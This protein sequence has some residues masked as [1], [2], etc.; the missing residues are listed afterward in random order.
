METSPSK[1]KKRRKL[2]IVK[3]IFAGLSVVSVAIIIPVGAQ[4]E[5][6]ETYWV[7][8]AVLLG[9]LGICLTAWIII[10]VDLATGHKSKWKIFGNI[11]LLVA[12][13]LV[14]IGVF[15]MTLGSYATTQQLQLE[16]AKRARF[17]QDPEILVAL[18]DVGAKGDYTNLI[19][20]QADDMATTCG[21][22]DA[23][24][25]Y[26]TNE[27][28]EPTIYV[29]KGIRQNDPQYYGVIVAHEYL[30]YVWYKNSLDSDRALTSALI[31]LYS[32][33]H[34]LQE[35]LGASSQNH[36]LESGGLA[37]TEFFSYGCTESTESELG[38]YIWSRCNEYID[39]S[40]LAQ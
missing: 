40:T 30:H 31:D 11:L 16:E 6:G 27:F 4:A 13:P 8:A 15:M 2:S 20:Q 25:C 7:Q 3:W 21:W 37:P 35:R 38:P 9:S 29:K 32:K 12:L 34:T 17:Y 22:Q 24:G 5:I 1:S 26:K 28:N 10:I 36:Y 33:N 18:R 39:T 23:G 14:C 19:L